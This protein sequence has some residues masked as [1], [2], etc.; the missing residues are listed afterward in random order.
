MKVI[1]DGDCPV[2]ISLKEFS[3]E[4]ISGSEIEFIPYQQA[5]LDRLIPTLTEED[6]SQSIFVLGDSGQHR[7]GARAVFEIMKK[8]PGIGSVIGKFMAFPPLSWLAE[9]FYRLFAR[10]RHNV[11]RW[12][13]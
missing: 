13:T 6:A 2:C 1:Y 7:R 12:F 10:H 8:M 11:S 5:Y 9:P 4:Q 3:D